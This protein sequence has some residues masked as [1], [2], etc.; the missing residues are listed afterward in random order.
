MNKKTPREKEVKPW[1]N[2]RRL[3]KIRFRCHPTQRAQKQV[4]LFLKSTVPITQKNVKRF[5]K[6]S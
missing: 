1:G 5:F 4:V 6:F 2:K 3:E